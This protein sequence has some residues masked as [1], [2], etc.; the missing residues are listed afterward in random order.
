ML[1]VELLQFSMFDSNSTFLLGE[2]HYWNPLEREERILNFSLQTLAHF[3][4]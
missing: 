2:I 4:F 3:K 1:R